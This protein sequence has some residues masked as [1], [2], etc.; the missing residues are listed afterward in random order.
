[1]KNSWYIIIFFFVINCSA[2]KISNTHG[3]RFIETKYDKIFINKT[4]KNDVQKLI[5]P[6]STISDFGDIWFYIERRKTNQSLIKLGKKRISANNILIV[7]F[8]NLGLVSNKKKLNVEDMNDLKVLEDFTQKNFKQNNL[9][10]DV[11]S[12]LR[13]KINAPTRKKKN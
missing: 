8:N 2:N 4:N 13:E 1:M 10:Y 9:I 5:G 7:S 6:P 12:T 11:L 3:Y